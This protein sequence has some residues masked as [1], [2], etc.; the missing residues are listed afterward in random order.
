MASLDQQIRYPIHQHRLDNGLRVVISPDPAVPAVAVNLWYDVGSADEPP[1]RTGFAHLFEHLMFQGSSQVRAGDHLGLLQA[2]GGS[3]N[4]TTS[5]DR[6]NYYESVPTGALRLALWLEADR[7]GTLLDAVDQASLDNQREVVKEEK[8]QR[9]DNVP[10]G[11]VWQHLLELSFPADHPYGHTTI[12]S[13]ADLDAATLADVRDFF[14]RHYRPSRAVLTLVGDITER[15]GLALAQQYFGHLPARPG[16]RRPQT[17]ALPAHSGVPRREVSTDVPRDAVY[18]AW[19]LPAAGHPDLEALGL[20][21]SVLGDGLTSRLHQALVRTEL[22]EH[23]GAFTLSLARGNSIAVGY[24]RCWDEVSLE[25]LEQELVTAWDELVG[26][27]P[28][29]AE[30]A[31]SVAQLTREWLTELAALDQRADRIGQATCLLDDPDW[32]NTRL[33]TVRAL[34]RDQVAAAAQRWLRSDQRAVLHYRAQ[35]A[36]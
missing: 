23:A 34:T 15:R 3:V 25:R 1:G 18:L 13:M 7:L 14:E 5:F 33:A 22:A 27:G 20:A 10:Y 29:E 26:T 4:G 35:E 30:H 31:R 6:T 16:R 32:I 21:T 24:A 11:N 9:Y 17:P 28:T 2:A 19:R 36:R 12:G 8:R